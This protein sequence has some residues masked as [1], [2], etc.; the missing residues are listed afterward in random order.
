MALAGSSFPLRT[1]SSCFLTGT[2]S[3]RAGEPLLLNACKLLTLQQCLWNCLTVCASHG[4]NSTLGT[5]LRLM[6]DGLGTQRIMP[7]ERMVERLMVTVPPLVDAPRSLMKGE[8]TQIVRY[9]KGESYAKHFDIK[10]GQ[11]GAG[12]C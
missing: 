2:M 5:A 7:S 3:R 9:R 12:A 4:L 6:S 8:A 11:G 1:S 10:N